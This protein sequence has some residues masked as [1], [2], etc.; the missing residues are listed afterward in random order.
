MEHLWKNAS[1]LHAWSGVF[2]CFT[3]Y[4]SKRQRQSKKW[5]QIKSHTY[6]YALKFQGWNCQILISL[7][8]LNI[9]DDLY[10]DF[11]LERLSFWQ[12]GKCFLNSKCN[13]TTLEYLAQAAKFK[14]SLIRCFFFG[15]C[16]KLVVRIWREAKRRGQRTMSW[17]FYTWTSVVNKTIYILSSTMLL[18]V[19]IFCFSKDSSLREKAMNQNFMNSF[20]ISLTRFD[21]RAHP[22]ET[23]VTI[24]K[25]FLFKTEF[26]KTFSHLRCTLETPI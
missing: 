16:W 24:W 12:N 4:R 10:F 26:M 7:M 18:F 2:H 5:C 6:Q 21:F 22:P 14:F 19:I 1:Q 20:H 15:K 9:L 11:S 23:K 17:R 3:I 25:S 8:T 13:R